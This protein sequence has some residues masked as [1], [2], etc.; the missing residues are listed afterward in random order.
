MLR[1]L[2]TVQNLNKIYLRSR[3]V[4]SMD[5]E[6]KILG[7]LNITPLLK[8]QK[9]FE[10]S[11]KEAHSALERD[12]AIQRFEYTYELVWKTLKRILNFKGIDINN[13]RDV[14][15]EAAK[16]KFIE[17]ATIWFVFLKQRNLTVH[18]YNQD[19]AAEIFSYLPQFEKELTKVVEAIK[20]L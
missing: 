17:D 10:L 3:K 19:C 6:I 5:K 9:T 8:A 2:K 11:L 15:R 14:F 13:P 7:E 20:R 16:Q 4:F 1:Y 12:G 18:T